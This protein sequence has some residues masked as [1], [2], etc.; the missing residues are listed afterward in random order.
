MMAESVGPVR[1]PGSETAAR[2]ALRMRY[3]VLGVVMAVVWVGHS[4]E[5]AWQHALRAVLVLL[6]IAP[7]MTVLRHRLRRGLGE[8]RGGQSA[9][10]RWYWTVARLVVIKLAHLAL[11]LGV[12]WLIGLWLAPVGHGES[13]RG[14]VL[15]LVL[16]AALII[17]MQLR[18]RRRGGEGAA[19]ILWRV[20]WWR[21]VAAK[22]VLIA[23]ALGVEVVLDP[24]LAQA[25]LIVAAA[26]AVTVAAVG[27]R[28]HPH[29]IQRDLIQRGSPAGPDESGPEQAGAHT[30]SDVPTAPP[31]S[32]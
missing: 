1:L 7:V 11:V 12:T 28:L 29:L 26:L 22:I 18:A 21:L 19:A 15:R 8:R 31:R 20:S 16:L 32:S 5:P 3:V 13:I 23:A 2:R 4:G 10:S 6:S 24:W 9:G 27:P 17:P 30:R 14:F 25:N